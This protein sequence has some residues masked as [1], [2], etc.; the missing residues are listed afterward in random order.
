[1]PHDPRSLLERLLPPALLLVAAGVMLAWTW[2]PWADPL[3]DTGRELY[4]PWRLT[5]GEVL[6]RDLAW[7]NGPLS[8]YC[9]ALLF[10]LF[11]V[12][13]DTLVRANLLLLAAAVALLHALVRRVWG[14][15]AAT[16]GGLVFLVGFAFGPLLPTSNFTWVFPY[17]HEM[18]HGLVLAFAALWLL[19][20]HRRSGRAAPLALAGL[21]TG[22]CFLTKPEVFLAVA[23]GAAAALFLARP[24]PARLLLFLGAALAP[25]L[26]AWAALATALPANDAFHG[27]LGGWPYVPLRALREQFF[28]RY[29]FGTEP[30][31]RFLDISWKWAAIEALILAFGA[32]GAFLL[33][34]RSGG[35][36]AIVAA[37]GGL[38]AFMVLFQC[39]WLWPYSTYPL[40]LLLIA[41]LAAGV[42]RWL[43]ARDDPRVALRIAF[44][45][46]AL[47]LLPKILLSVRVTQYGFGLVLPGTLV[48]LGV[49]LHD[50]P[51]WMARRGWS[52]WFFRAVVLAALVAAAENFCDIYY[53]RLVQRVGTVGTGRDLL[54]ADHR[55]APIRGMLEEV[56][57]RLGPDQTVAVFPEGATLNYFAR[58]RTPARHLN[59]LP[60]ELI[61]FGEDRIVEELRARPPD[62][63]ILVNRVMEEYGVERWGKEY[64]GRLLAWMQTSYAFVNRY[65]T[66]VP[67]REREGERFIMELYQRK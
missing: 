23:A 43:R 54:L 24:R 40:P 4:V 48:A 58:R 9:N 21:A 2:N 10:R 26:I 64:G 63:L 60:P 66:P 38:V 29:T 45:V 6:Y 25:P 13:L 19:D 55:A 53:R 15:L 52:G 61:M 28:Y 62:L 7:F 27:V 47:G 46:F 34:R 44:T 51:A 30:K 17:S 31:G 49:L 1:M 65:D 39:S 8:P 20:R 50:V 12:G 41:L 3:V 59:Y 18:T 14:T 11:G 37:G 16:V 22:L 42:V 32:A 36:R 35:G 67:G 56:G 33:R 5:E 57:K